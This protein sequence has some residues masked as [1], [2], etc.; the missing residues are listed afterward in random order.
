VTGLS[1]NTVI[2][3]TKAL[4]SEGILAVEEVSS[5]GRGKGVTYRVSEDAAE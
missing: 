3:K 2:S 4:V 5:G 1:L